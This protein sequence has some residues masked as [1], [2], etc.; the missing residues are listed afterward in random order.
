VFQLI[1]F[2]IARFSAAH[3][4][5]ERGNKKKKPDSPR[6]QGNWLR[7]LQW[8]AE[9]NGRRLFCKLVNTWHAINCTWLRC[10]MEIFG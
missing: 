8:T 1:S 2:I 3:C 5:M 10:H 7:G 9:A 6:V 4:V